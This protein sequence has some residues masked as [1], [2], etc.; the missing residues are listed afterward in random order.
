MPIMSD[1]PWP[2]AP[3]SRMLCDVGAPAFARPCVTALH[4]SRQLVRL[5]TTLTGLFELLPFGRGVADQLAELI[6]Q[7]LASQNLGMLREHLDQC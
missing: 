5:S 2:S 6:A 4:L 3:A 7:F 1:L